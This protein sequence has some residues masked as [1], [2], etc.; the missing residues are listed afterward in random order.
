MTIGSVPAAS[1]YSRPGY[2]LHDQ[3]DAGTAEEPGGSRRENPEPTSLKP[4]QAARR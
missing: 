1:A 3:N 2:L 4:A